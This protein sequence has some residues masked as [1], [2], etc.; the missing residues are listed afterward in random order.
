MQLRTEQLFDNSQ[1]Y[2][3]A[4]LTSNYAKMMGLTVSEVKQAGIQMHH[5]I[6]AALKDMPFL[7]QIGFNVD[8]AL[9]AIPLR[10]S[11]HKWS[12]SHKA[13]NEA[14]EDWLDNI[15]KARHLSTAA[16]RERVMELMT[17]AS[18]AIINGRG[19]AA[20][21]KAAATKS[22]WYDLLKVTL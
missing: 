4:T 1:T 15:R 11:V 16:K 17:N 13:Y 21:G 19:L 10:A 6:P 9:N 18:T 2:A 7:K 5:I 20:T 3:L 14:I 12:G 8:A 22:E